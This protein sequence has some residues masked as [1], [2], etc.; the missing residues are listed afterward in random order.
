MVRTSSVRPAPISPKSPTIS[1]R[2]TC[3]DTGGASLV[4]RTSRSSRAISP[5]AESRDGKKSSTWRP[6]IASTRS[7]VLTSAW[8]RVHTTAPSR[9]TV[10]RSAI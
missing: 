1:P 6:T 2:R 4:M 9:I 5:M 7:S 10:T 8:L 3:S